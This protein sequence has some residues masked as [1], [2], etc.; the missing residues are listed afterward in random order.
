ME[1]VQRDSEEIAFADRLVDLMELIDLEDDV[2]V[3]LAVELP[4]ELIEAAG[5]VLENCLD[6]S[7]GMSRQDA[8]ADDVIFAGQAVIG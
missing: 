6:A 2:D 1:E 4:E 3:P 8:E 7:S 5:T